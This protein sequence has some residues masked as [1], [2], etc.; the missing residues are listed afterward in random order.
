MKKILVLC[1]LIGLFSSLSAAYIVEENVTVDLDDSAVEITVNADDMN[2]D[3]FSYITGYPVEEFHRGT[4][5]DEELEC[6]VEDL[7]PGSSISCDIGE[8]DDFEIQLEFRGSELIGQRNNVSIFRYNHNIYR[9]TDYYQLEVYLPTGSSLA[10]ENDVNETVIYPE[11]G[12]ITSDGQRHIVSWQQE[13]DG[14]PNY[15][16]QTFFV[17]NNNGPS[18]IVYI[19]IGLL[20]SL[21]IVAAGLISWRIYQERDVKSVFEELTEDEKDI[22]DTLRDNDNSMLQKDIVNESEYSKAKISGV[23]SKLVDKEIIDKE[24]EGRSNKLVLKKKYRN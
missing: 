3:S 16:F 17:E 23:V 2:S 5:G 8:R 13:P 9:S 12:E 1:V 7:P 20:G 14:L 22:V 10:S 6:S 19:L 18:S 4:I 15:S 24:K 21:A 11:H